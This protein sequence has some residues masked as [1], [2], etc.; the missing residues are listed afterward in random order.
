MKKKKTALLQ[1]IPMLVC[2]VIGGV[3]G[4]LM[5]RYIDPMI[6]GKSDSA[7]IF[8]FIA[9][10]IELYAAIYLQIIIHEA[11]HLVFGLL[12]GYKYSSF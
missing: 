12:S 5:V 9:A 11:G 10:I 4:A 1:Y 6:E 7:I 3:C 8:F 2:L